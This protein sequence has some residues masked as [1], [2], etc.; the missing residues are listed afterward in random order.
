MM[1]VCTLPYP[2]VPV[3]SSPSNQSG[4]PPSVLGGGPSVRR[5]LIGV[6]YARAATGIAVTHVT[7]HSEPVGPRP[8][9]I[10]YVAK[11][12]IAAF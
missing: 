5:R 8:S 6:D 9:A 2:C 11:G 7:E 4:R 12:W 1:M 3:A 10:G